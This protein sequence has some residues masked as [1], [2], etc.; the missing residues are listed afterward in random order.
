MVRLSPG[1]CDHIC[2]MGSNLKRD[3]KERER[4]VPVSSTQCQW[5][6][7]S[8]WV[9]STT[10]IKWST[11]E[12]PSSP[13]FPCKAYTHTHTHSPPTQVIDSRSFEYAD[14]CIRTHRP[15]IAPWWWWY[16]SF[17]H[18]YCCSTDSIT[19]LH[20]RRR[21]RESE[22]DRHL[23]IKD[24]NMLGNNPTTVTVMCMCVCVC[25][26]VYVYRPR[27]QKCSI[28]WTTDKLALYHT[29][30]RSLKVKARL[31][32]FGVARSPG[33]TADR[34]HLHLHSCVCVCCIDTSRCVA[35]CRLC[36]CR[37]D[38]KFLVASTGMEC[39]HIQTPSRMYSIDVNLIYSS[40]SLANSQL[41]QTVTFI[42]WHKLWP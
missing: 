1:L 10:F 14:R 9:I 3:L 35:T 28:G 17:V 21:G 2:G 26:C 22:R 15:I 18:S 29:L 19:L 8:W 37:H 24:R 16:S 33:T 20:E 7:Y 5:C 23:Q 27:L 25:V 40:Q 13:T 38:D 4:E 34:Q 42:T 32:R 36:E 6:V 31:L 41:V 11:I 30:L 39:C 12:W